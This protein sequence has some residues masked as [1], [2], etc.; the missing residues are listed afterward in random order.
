METVQ[1]FVTEL[2]RVV[3]NTDLDDPVKFAAFRQVAEERIQQFAESH[4]VELKKENEELKE[5][6]GS[7]EGLIGTLEGEV[8]KW[9]L[10]FE[11][12]SFFKRD[13]ELQHLRELIFRTKNILEWLIPFY[14]NGVPDERG[15]VPTGDSQLDRMQ[16]L[17][18][19]CE[20]ALNG[21]PGNTT[22]TE[23]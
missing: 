4:A 12:T 21:Q 15:Y 8:E 10:R 19:D 16:Q 20:K 17:L 18:Q 2:T 3:R 7:M 1:A 14:P 23:G 13:A 6:Q 11:G 22:S 9:R 5:T